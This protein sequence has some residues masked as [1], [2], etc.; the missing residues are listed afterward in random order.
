MTTYDHSPQRL[1]KILAAAGYGSRRAC[2]D[3]IVAGRV[4]VD[5]KTVR[6][7]GTKVDPASQEIRV[8]GEV[9]RPPRFVYY[10]LHKPRGVVSTA[11]DPSGRPRAIDLVPDEPRVFPVGRLDISSEGLLLLTNDGDLAQ[12]LTHPKFEVEKEYEVLVAGEVSRE[13]MAKIQ[14]GMH[15]AEGF[16]RPKRIRF[17][18]NEGKKATWLEMV[19]DEGKNREIR[20]IFARGGHKVLRLR[21]VAVGSLRLGEVPAGAFRELKPEEVSKLRQAA[22][23]MSG[24]PGAA[25]SRPGKRRRSGGQTTAPRRTVTPGIRRQAAGGRPRTVGG[26]RKQARVQK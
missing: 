12:R 9:L 4:E 14:K 22:A 1:Q 18:R 11:R 15:L 24:K 26:K 19:L 23:G 5:R 10:L 6:E 3:L 2:E 13:E 21:R 25:R 16:A 7:L 8:D 17:K 20:R